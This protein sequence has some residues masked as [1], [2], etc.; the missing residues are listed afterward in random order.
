MKLSYEDTVIVRAA[1]RILREYGARLT[2]S[3]DPLAKREG[4]VG[5][6]ADDTAAELSEWLRQAENAGLLPE[7]VKA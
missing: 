5:Y 2:D 1:A 3:Y 7:T 6:L 4:F